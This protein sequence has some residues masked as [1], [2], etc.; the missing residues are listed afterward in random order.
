MAAAV[1][2]LAAPPSVPWAGNQPPPSGISSTAAGAALSPAG[3]AFRRV[4]EMEEGYRFL[5]EQKFGEARERFTR[6]SETNPADPFGE[7]SLA[8]AHLFEE[9]FHQGV[10][11]SDYF[12][13][14]RRFL[15]GIEGTP[16]PARL[17]AFRS[18]LDHARAS[19][20]RL[21]EKDPR[22]AEALFTM[23][24]AAGMES[25]A[26]SILQKQNLDGLRR[27]K[28]SNNWAERLLAV[29]PDASDAWLA[30][31]SA[32]Y[33]IGCLPTTVRF[34]LWFGGFHGDRALGMQQLEKTATGGLYL[35][36]YA[37]ILLALAARREGQEDLAR[38]ELSELTRDYPASPLF[39]AEYA[40]LKPASASGSLSR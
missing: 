6:W 35:Q 2:V 26:L 24:L 31:G 30:L 5:Y 29:R 33:V 19:A 21:L 39:A 7:I 25:N 37:K 14:D 16:D 38:R 32:N 8:A 34:L 17:R 23:T 18:A 10:M 27:L 4:P 22:D 9:F 3:A 12:L 11:T 36:P 40:R 13:D 15:K 28:E 1:L 20:A